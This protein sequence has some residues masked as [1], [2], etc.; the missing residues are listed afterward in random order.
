M[1]KNKKIVIVTI[2]SMIFIVLF[3][4]VMFIYRSKSTNISDSV[5]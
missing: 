2:I 4:T 5:K 1:S 3:I